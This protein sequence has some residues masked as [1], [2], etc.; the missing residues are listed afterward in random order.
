MYLCIF[1]LPEIDDA[2][3]LGNHKVCWT[4]VTFLHV[5]HD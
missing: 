2:D 1:Q 3:N 4:K 5:L